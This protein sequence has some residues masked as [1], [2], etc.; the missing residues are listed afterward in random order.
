[1]YFVNWE[2]AKDISEGSTINGSST[3]LRDPDPVI[4]FKRA[5]TSGGFDFFVLNPL[6][7]GN[8]ETITE[9]ALLCLDTGLYT[10]INE[11]LS[12]GLINRFQNQNRID[13]ITTTVINKTK[14][15]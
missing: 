2:T 3:E 15:F 7:L 9:P 8:G 11:I 14:R 5:N 13:K 4:L 1:M 12:R 6:L 10:S